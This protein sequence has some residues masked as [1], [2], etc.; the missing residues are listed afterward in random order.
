VDPV[1]VTAVAW[2]IAG[3]LSGLSTL[4]VVAATGPSQV[5]GV[6]A[7]VPPLAALILAGT[8]SLRLG[9]L[10]A[11]A[12]GVLQQ[13][14]VWSYGKGD[15]LDAILLGAV[16]AV[17]LARHRRSSERVDLTDSSW[18]AAREVRRV[19]PELRGHPEVRRLHI[20]A[21]VA[22]AMIAVLYPFVMPTGDVTTGS[23]TLVYAIIGL[24][25]LMLTGWSGLIS[26]GQFAFAAVGAFVTAVLVGK[27]GVPALPALVLGSLAGGAV[28]LV[29]GIPAL[30]IR[31]LYL[32]VVTLALSVTTATMVVN[33]AYA[34]RWLPASLNRPRLFGLSTDDERAFYFLCLVVTIGCLL[35]VAGLRRSK[36]AR[37]LIASRDNERAAELFGIDLVRAR[38]LAFVVS[39]VLAALAGGLFAFSQKGVD[40]GNFS[41]DQ[42]LTM[43]LMVII[44]G[45]GSLAGPVL[46]AVFLGVLTIVGNSPASTGDSWSALALPIAVLTVLM[47]APG[48]LTQALF[49]ARD[50]RLRQI[51]LRHRIVVPSLV[52]ANHPGWTPDK[53]V[54]LAAEA[55]FVEPRYTLEH[56]PLKVPKVASTGR[57]A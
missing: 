26:L 22:A 34:G 6:I 52:D 51:A 18:R 1:K 20:R 55:G 25:L 56:R 5:G 14:L 37:A 11:L 46:G 35:A 50:A 38:L 40:V 23:I 41:A 45:L 33:P 42:S 53:R 48:G 32:A 43:F 21:G 9:M 3:A 16:V 28:A 4:L 24:S 7:F 13:G 10:A 54:P 49:A 31:G 8:V 17:L 19:P 29:V 30:R 12:T 57:G 44:G 39:G 36:T 47:V 27:V 2:M 15:V